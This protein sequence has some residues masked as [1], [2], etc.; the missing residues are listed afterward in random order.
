MKN[1]RGLNYHR[2]VM[3]QTK[4]FSMAR[5]NQPTVTTESIVPQKVKIFVWWM[6]YRA[7]PSNSQLIKRNVLVQPICARC[8]DEV[9]TPEHALSRLEVLVELAVVALEE[10]QGAGVRV[11]EA[12]VTS[13]GG[14]N[15]M[16]G[17][18]VGSSGTRS[19]LTVV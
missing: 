1:L 19:L 14:G 5:W 16:G 11:L 8:G 3:S 2:K 10:F 12:M 4:K 15:G 9:E 7:L 6:Y 18:V 17:A 13:I